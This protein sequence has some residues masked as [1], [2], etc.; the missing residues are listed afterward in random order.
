MSLL[1]RI[2]FALALVV[3]FARPPAYAEWAM[4]MSNE[5]ATYYLD[6][7]TIRRKGD[8]VKVWE[9]WDFKTIQ[10]IMGISHLSSKMQW[11]YDCV[12]E[13]SRTLVYVNFAGNMG[14]GERVH[15]DSDDDKG[16]IDRWRPI[17]PET[18]GQT[19]WNAAC[20]KR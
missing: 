20:N 18:L 6:P 11:E 12:E 16:V 9:L 13:R 2:L 7:G 15:G 17:V 3:L 8:I 10:T 14:K 1:I 5:K 4:I 19:L